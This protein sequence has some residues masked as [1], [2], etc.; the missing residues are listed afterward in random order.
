MAVQEKIK[1]PFPLDWWFSTSSNGLGALLYEI[2]FILITGLLFKSY[3]SESL[4]SFRSVDHKLKTTGWDSSSVELY[5]L[6]HCIFTIHPFMDARDLKTRWNSVTLLVGSKLAHRSLV[7]ELGG[8][9][10]FHFCFIAREL[11]SLPKICIR[12]LSS[13]KHYSLLQPPGSCMPLKVKPQLSK[14]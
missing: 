1:P 10:L 9:T 14:N 7:L 4:Y 13:K 5:G 12:K 2:L 3:W 8:G 6:A 11:F